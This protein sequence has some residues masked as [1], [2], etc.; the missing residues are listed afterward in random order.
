MWASQGVE[1][2]PQ[3]RLPLLGGM[4]LAT[5]QECLVFIESQ[6]IDNT[7]TVE[8]I[9]PAAMTPATLSQTQVATADT[10]AHPTLSFL[11][12]GETCC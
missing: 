7:T 8:Q 4:Q 12:S 11:A 2:Q 9:S 10:R 5:T 3:A 6:V 1:T